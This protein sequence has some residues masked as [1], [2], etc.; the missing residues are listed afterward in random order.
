MAI[1]P[2]TIR[3]IWG[4]GLTITGTVT[5]AGSTPVALEKQDFPFTGAWA[6]I[7]TATANSQRR[8]HA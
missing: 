7:A 8:V 6:Q 5:G 4:T 1:T 2:S 3:P